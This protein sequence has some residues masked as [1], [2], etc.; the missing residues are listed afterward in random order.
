MEK[1][2]CKEVNQLDLVDFLAGLGHSP[3]KIRNNDYWYISPL[4]HRQEKTPSF[5][6]DRRKNVWYDHGTGKGGTLVDFGILYYHCSIADLL[7]RLAGYQPTTNFSFH[8]PIQAR[9][10]QPAPAIFAGEKKENASGKIVVL[11]T[12]PL[13]LPGLIQ[14]LEKRQIPV[15]IAARFCKEVDFLLY[16]KKHSAIG[17]QNNAG[18]Y[19]LRSGNFKGSSAPKDITFLDNGR[20]QVAVFEGLF[21]F[22]S[23]QAINQNQQPPLSNCL[24]LNSLAFLER[25]RPLLEQHKQ[26]HLVLDRDTAGKN[27]TSL[28]LQWDKEK[29]IDRSD[30]YH[31]HKDLNDWLTHHKHNRGQ[32]QRPGKAL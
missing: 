30:F 4:P 28:A 10:P 27:C 16:G 17:F 13:A 22:L 8:P 29:Y 31:P 6:V 12:R 26:V 2:T 15:K 32:S 19:E 11:D 20:D 5:K 9:N 18:G 14:Y 24:V 1:V 7:Q 21:S 25:S 23:F 3:K